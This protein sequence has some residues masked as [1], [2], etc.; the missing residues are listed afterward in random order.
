MRRAPFVLS[1]EVGWM[2]YDYV[3]GGSAPRCG[4]DGEALVFPDRDAAR[5]FI[6]LAPGRRLAAPAPAGDLDREVEG[7][8]VGRA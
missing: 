1:T 4:G 2:I 8:D 5:R 6:G 7:S 3:E